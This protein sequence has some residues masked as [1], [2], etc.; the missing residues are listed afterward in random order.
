MYNALFHIKTA[1][2]IHKGLVRQNNQDRILV[3]N[4][5]NGYLLAVADGM[6]GEARGEDAAEMVIQHLDDFNPS[7]DPE[8]ELVRCIKE[9][10]RAVLRY[11]NTNQDFFGMGST[12][13]A[14]FI[15]QDMLHWVNLGD[16]RL[17][18]L[19][20]DELIQITTDHNFIQ[21]LVE[22]GDISPEEALTN[23]MRNALERAVG[24]P[25]DH[26][27]DTG[28]F[29]IMERDIILI[30]SDGLYSMIGDNAMARILASSGSL[31]EKLDILQQ[32]ALDNG[33]RDNIAIAAAEVTT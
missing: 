32:A 31:D 11:A 33:G 15:N 2:R 12:A 24:I 21:E 13:V 20:K 10:S 29:H 3:K 19:R 17:Y 18:L 22:A 23:P 25:D 14:V 4:T 9:A 30:C 16:S 27:P 8:D 26:L 28:R 1:A 5:G 7:A 6:G